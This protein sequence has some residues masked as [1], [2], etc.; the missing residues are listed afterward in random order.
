MKLLVAEDERELS[1]ALCAI[2]RHNNYT[3][4]AVYDGRDALD[5]MLG[6]DYDAAVLDLMMPLL[7]GIQVLKRARGEGI[8]TPVIILTAKSEVEDRVAGLDSGADDYLTKPF[9]TSELL[10]RIRAITRRPSDRKSSLLTFGDLTLDL[11]SYELSCAGGLIRLTN[12]EYQIIELL[13]SNPTMLIS[14]ERIMDKVWGYESNAEM[15]V[16]WVYISNLRKKL[17]RLGSSVQIKALRN[18][19]YLLEEQY[20]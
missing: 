18:S 19:G 15:N 3:V 9:A 1:N 7:D 17:S 12:K 10:A 6:G 14:T 5:Y 13:M 8:T 20:D 4:D 2:L 11:A 16:V